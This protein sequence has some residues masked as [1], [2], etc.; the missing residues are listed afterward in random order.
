MADSC[1]VYALLIGV[2]AVLYTLLAESHQWSGVLNTEAGHVF[3]AV[4]HLAL[5]RTANDTDIALG[6]N[7]N[8]DVVARWSVLRAFAQ[9]V[10]ATQR[11]A[12]DHQN[13]ETPAQLV[14][15]FLH[16]FSLGA[17]AERHVSRDLFLEIVRA[18]RALPD[19]ELSIGGNAA[20]M[21]TRIGRLGGKTILGGPVGD[22][23]RPL[24]HEN[25]RP[26]SADS[27]S[28]ADEY[29]L[30]LE[31]AV[32]DEFLGRRAS[33]AN[34]FILHSDDSNGRVS[35]AEALHEALA[36]RAPQLL[37]VAG[38]HLLQEQPAAYRTQRLADIQ[39]RLRA[40]PGRTAAHFELASVGEAAFLGQLAASVLPRVDSLG[41]NE[42]EL[43]DLCASLDSD[44]TPVDTAPF[45]TAPRELV[46]DALARVFRNADRLASSES[47]A[48]K[49]T[50][51]HFHY[52]T[53]HV[54]ATRGDAWQHTREA[55][56]AGSFAA[57]TQACDFGLRAE[58][59]K[60]RAI[61]LRVTM[62]D[63]YD[64]V[65]VVQRADITFYIVPVLV[66]KNPVRTVGL[67]DA[68]SSSALATSTWSK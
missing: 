19:T 32:G 41:L 44:D 55:I 8:V 15:C 24:L 45:A 35:G 33:R 53:Y 43:G 40:L 52:L 58:R 39:T 37:V 36:Q 42:Q 3:D 2:A 6:Y 46:L 30:I 64:P 25:V 67:G 11:I 38:L 48:R 66:C 28:S 56:A 18:A 63:H 49:L 26:V 47:D 7:C 5:K 12:Q 54:I 20:L 60:E 1:P 50:R 14:Q 29:H 4:R 27:A 23:L 17:A 61:E 9:Q 13:I 62:A 57:T 10:A 31:Y 21:A 16:Y 34:R 51:I 65:E 59:F 68:V 22:V